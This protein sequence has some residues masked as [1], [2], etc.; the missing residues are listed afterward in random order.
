MASIETR[1]NN[2]GTSYKVVWY[3]HDGKKR[4][5]TW[6]D[7]TRAQI[8]KN[9]IEAVKGDTEAAA[10]AL[11][12]QASTARTVEQVAKHRLS[13]IRATEF[14]KQT[15]ESYMRNHIGPAFGNWPI[16]TVTEDD[17]RRF[18]IGLENKNLSAKYISNIGGWVTS[19]MLHA[20]E[21][22]WRTGNPMLPE[23]LPEIVLTDAQ[24]EDK[25]L[26]RAEAYAI[27]ERM[28]AKHQLAALLMLGT[29]LRP[30]EMR[31]LKISDVHLD[32]R[33]PV[34]RVTKA[35]KQNRESG[36][37]VGPPKSKKAVRS[38]GLPHSIVPLLRAHVDGRSQGEYLFPGQSGKWIG[39]ET[40]YQAFIK[41]VKKAQEDKMLTKNPVPYSLRHTHAS[42]MIDNGMD[43]YK[44]SRHM[45]HESVKTTE[46]VYL[47][48]YPDAV[49][50]AAEIASAALGELPQLPA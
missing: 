31:A 10:Q 39:E 40:F 42:M 13:L 6:P 27:I 20:V 11:A 49:Y 48:L 1:T 29:G 21:R 33:Q 50:Q 17:C 3:D 36:A 35:I 41:G 34:V 16:D 45:G 19:I 15:Y 44:L 4:S 12:R 22:K 23:M 25:F 30:S 14:T 7:E 43:I 47:H 46:G 37:Y 8:W 24:E 2:K 32:A 26:T 28:P 9:L 38:L 5:K 18:I